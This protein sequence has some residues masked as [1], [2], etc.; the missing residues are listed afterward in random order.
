MS[1]HEREDDLVA[2]A[3]RLLGAGDVEAAGIFGLADLTAAMIGGSL[4]GSAAGSLLEG[5]AAGGPGVG[6][7]VGAG[8]GAW[9]AT[10][11]MAREKGVDLQMILALTPSGIYVLNREHGEQPPGV[12]ASFDRSRCEVKVTRLGLSRT[13]ELHDPDR[14]TSIALHGTVAPFMGRSA[15]DKAVIRLLTAA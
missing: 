13:V 8:V 7:A 3:N 5:E 12:V 4:A 2:E 11:A 1:H 6:D 9:A 10:Q 15:A 14:G